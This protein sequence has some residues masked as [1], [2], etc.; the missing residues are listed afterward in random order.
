[1]LNPI[2]Q[3][4]ANLI[5]TDVDPALRR[6]YEDIIRDLEAVREA[7]CPPG[8]DPEPDLDTMIANEVS[9]GQTDLFFLKSRV[10]ALPAETVAPIP[11]IGEGASEVQHQPGTLEAESLLETPSALVAAEE[12]AGGTSSI[13]D[14][15]D[16][17]QA[18]HDAAK[19]EPVGGADPAA[20]PAPETVAPEPAGDPIV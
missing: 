10:G 17:L 19:A 11:P 3:K 8:V 1:M 16:S 6:V 4:V 2:I 7:L 5:T 9:D 18:S 13:A 12:L 15:V 14:L 20:A